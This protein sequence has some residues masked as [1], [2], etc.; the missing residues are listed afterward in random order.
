MENFSCRPWT[1]E[2]KY[3]SMIV[4]IMLLSFTTAGSVYATS[5]FEDLGRELG[6]DLENLGRDVDRG[7]DD[8]QRGLDDGEEQG[9]NDYPYRDSSC[10]P[11]NSPAYCLG[12]STGYSKGWNAAETLSD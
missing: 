7:T 8:Y 1:K 11:G 5:F 9:E 2:L 4:T 12:Y 10:P 6:R 3:A